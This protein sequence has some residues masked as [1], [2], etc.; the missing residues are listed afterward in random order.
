[1]KRR[2]FLTGA[3]ALATAPRIAWGQ[4][5]KAVPLPPGV[6][7]AHSSVTSGR[8]LGSPSIA[9]LLG[10][11]YLASHD[12]FGP[13]GTKDT[14]WL[15]SSR[16]RG[17]HWKRLSTVEG[18]V[19]S[20]LFWHHGAL[21]LLSPGKQRGP[22]KIHRSDNGGKTWTVARNAKSGLLRTDGEF[23]SAPVPVIVHNGRIWRACEVSRKKGGRIPTFRTFVMSAPEDSDLLQADNWTYSNRCTRRPYLVEWKI[24]RLA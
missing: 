20:S 21:Y 19:W 5:Q 7:L 18:Q 16:D 17:A 10:G 13:K 11:T 12:D 15:Y 9:V 4:N 23:H 2:D 8:Y 6:V 1:M 22:I 24:R 14:T 3:A